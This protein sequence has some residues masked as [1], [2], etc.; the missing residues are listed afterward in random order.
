VL[1]GIDNSVPMNAETN[2]V[3]WL[4]AVLGYAERGISNILNHD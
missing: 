3:A 4:L 2:S 1:V